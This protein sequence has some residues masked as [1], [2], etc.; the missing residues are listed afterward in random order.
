MKIIYFIC[1]NKFTKRY[2]NEYHSK[3]FLKEMRIT[4]FLH[5]FPRKIHFVIIVFSSNL[6]SFSEYNIKSN[7]SKF[8]EKISYSLFDIF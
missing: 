2:E 8:E 7:K 3:K 4:S 5:H 6:F 1:N